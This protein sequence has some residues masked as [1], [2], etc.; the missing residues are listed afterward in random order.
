METMD[1]ID[2]AG[3]IPSQRT[4]GWWKVVLLACLCAF[5]IGGAIVRSAISRYAPLASDSF[6]NSEDW[7]IPP[8][9]EDVRRALNR[10]FRTATYRFGTTTTYA[11][12]IDN[13]GRWPVKVTGI[14]LPG[15]DE[16]RLMR[17]ERVSMASR[18]N[19]YGNDELIPFAPFTLEPGQGRHVAISARFGDCRWYEPGSSQ[20]LESV[21]V[22]FRFAGVDLTQNLELRRV[23]VV[24]SPPSEECPEPRALGAQPLTSTLDGTLAKLDHNLVCIDSVTNCYGIPTHQWSRDPDLKIGD[25]VRVTPGNDQMVGDVSRLG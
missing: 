10:S 12:G 11:F 21:G 16:L 23:L 9:D 4:G 19:S 15:P 5:L 13:H 2:V 3:P 7:Q 14:E 24:E 1:R 22:R 6:W 17:P 20:A 8:N 18:F 25:R